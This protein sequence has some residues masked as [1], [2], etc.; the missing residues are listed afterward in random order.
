MLSFLTDH[1]TY[2]LKTH[3]ESYHSILNLITL[4]TA[5]G[6]T[7]ISGIDFV[8]VCISDSGTN[9]GGIGSVLVR[10]RVVPDF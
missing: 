4:C 7:E 2:T 5:Q 1:G 10:I 8:F 3:H 6:C 9:Q